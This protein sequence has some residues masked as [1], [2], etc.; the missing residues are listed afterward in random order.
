MR[1]AVL[2][3]DHPSI[4]WDLLL[5]TAAGCWTWRLSESPLTAQVISAERI[6]DHRPLYL[7]YE[8]PVS[9]NRGVVSQVDV[10]KWVWITATPTKVSGLAVG[11]HWEGR[12]ALEAE[13][14]DSWQLQFFPAEKRESTPTRTALRNDGESSA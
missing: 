2:H 14:A 6:A 3:H 13:S 11:R 1:F 9:G 4:H 5:E 12:V 8:G 10:G 7:D